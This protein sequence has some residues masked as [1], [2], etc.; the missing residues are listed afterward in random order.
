MPHHTLVHGLRLGM[1]PLLTSSASAVLSGA[2][3]ANIHAYA[4]LHLHHR[5]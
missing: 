3:Q 1:Q 4:H 5:R 2:T